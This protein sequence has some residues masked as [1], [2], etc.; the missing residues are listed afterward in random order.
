MK[1]LFDE[2]LAPSLVHRLADLFE[3]SEH[4]RNLGLMQIPDTDVWHQAK[5]LGFASRGRERLLPRG[6]CVIRRILR[7]YFIKR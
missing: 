4:V 3:D 5:N 2:M 6:D 7:C 1:L